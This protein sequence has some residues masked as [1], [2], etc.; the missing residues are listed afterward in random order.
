MLGR[1]WPQ[2]TL[3]A[4]MLLCITAA[5]A[6]A[7]AFPPPSF[8]K[9][10]GDAPARTATVALRVHELTCRGRANLF[11]YFLE[12][13]DDYA[14][15]GYVKIEAWPDPALADVRII[16]DPVTANENAV[17]QAITEPYFDAGANTWRSSPFTIEGYDPLQ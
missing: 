9:S 1:S 6:A 10:R 4:V 17:K 7:Y 8:M 15:R 14:V 11:A 13:D 3:V 16:Y 5:V 2:A 12:R